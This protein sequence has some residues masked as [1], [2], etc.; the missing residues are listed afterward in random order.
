MSELMCPRDGLRCV[1]P[2][3]CSQRAWCAESARL[4][5]QPAAQDQP[6]SFAEQVRDTLGG[7]NMAAK[8]LGLDQSGEARQ[9]PQEDRAASG[10]MGAVTSPDPDEILRLSSFLQQY[11]DKTYW[12]VE[13]EHARARAER[14]EAERDAAIKALRELVDI[15]VQDMP[16]LTSWQMQMDAAWT[17]ACAVVAAHRQRVEK[18]AEAR[19]GFET[20]HDSEE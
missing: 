3:P 13:C 11:P 9:A 15:Y 2:D 12:L 1:C 17:A 16:S 10:L 19:E 8:A 20:S 14:V 6:P 4:K 5:A 7:L 18:T